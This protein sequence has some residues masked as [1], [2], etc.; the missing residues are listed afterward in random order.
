MSLPEIRKA[1]LTGGREVG[2]ISTFA[3]ALADGFK[4]LGYGAEVI[5][6]RSVLGRRRELGDPAV[7]KIL[8]TEA[9]FAAPFARRAICV[10]HGF[11]RP[12]SCGWRRTLAILAS[13][14]LANYSPG[15]RLA[16][17]SDYVAAHLRGVYGLRV[18]AVIRNP[19]QLMF[20]E[21]WEQPADRTTERRYLTYAGRLV[22]DKNLHRLLPT[23]RRLL[24]EDPALRICVIG[25]GPQRRELVALAEGDARVEFTGSLSSRE[26]RARLR[27][28][29]VFVSGNEL[30]PLAIVYMEALSQGCALAMP[31]CGG[32]IEIAPE[33]IGSRIFLLPLS[34]APPQVLE[35][36]RRAAAAP[37]AEPCLSAY[38]PADVARAYLEA[39][40][41]TGSQATLR[42]LRENAS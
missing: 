1:L 2:G 13:L 8:S 34:F 30:E 19:L 3:L 38:R 40:P 6:P 35:T 36:L 28:T 7:L 23:M 32:G 4:A 16:A 22:P 27:Q 20:F 12:H 18:D 26:V 21:P 42:A 29:R 25:D 33:L 17:V 31:A 41:P 37:V 24:E 14:K 9:V 39:A 10:A 11:P 5:S 15:C